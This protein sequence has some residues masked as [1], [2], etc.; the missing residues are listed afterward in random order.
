MPDIVAGLKTYPSVALLGPRQCGKSTLAHMLMEQRKPDALL[1]D[2][3]RP[4]DRARLTE[5]E[6]FFDANADRLICLDEIQRMPELFPLIRHILDKRGT[7]G[8]LLLLGSASRDVIESASESLA[9]RV[10]YLELTPF[11]HDEIQQTHTPFNDYWMRGGFPRSLL[12]PSEEAS[13]DWRQEFI[14]SFLERDLLQLKIRLMPERARRL[15]TMCAHCHGQLLNKS[16]LASALDVDSHTVDNYLDILEAAFMIR[17][18]PSFHIN[19]KKRLVKRPKIYIRDSGILHAL[20]GIADYNALL[21]H[22]VRGF[23]WEGLVLDQIL[24]R[25]SPLTQA[26]F[27]RTAKGAEAD[28]VLERGGRKA[29][30]EIKASATPDPASGFWTVLDDLQP[31]YVRIIAPVDAAYPLKQGVQVLPLQAFLKDSRA[32]GWLK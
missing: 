29:V 27:Y 25:L 14:R 23:S 10:K 20:L 32:A 19:L 2:L 15:W 8:Q 28:L 5:A 26:T 22:P 9:G 18:L 3:E 21:A 1:L 31:E 4:A 24:S 11:L 17:R 16:Q 6:A 30:I 7:P 13:M 12:A